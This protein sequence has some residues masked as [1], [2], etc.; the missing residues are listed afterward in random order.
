MAQNLAATVTATIRDAVPFLV[1]TG[2]WIVV[3]LVLYGIFLVTKPQ[4]VDYAAWVHASVFV[5]PGIGF[6]GHVF[7]QALKG[8]HAG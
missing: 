2:L 4:Q 1:I 7:Y 8:V 5:V 3:M 6:L